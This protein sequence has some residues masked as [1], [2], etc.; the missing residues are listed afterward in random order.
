MNR[1]VKTNAY[2]R[3]RSPAKESWTACQCPIAAN[4]GQ[5]SGG[6]VGTSRGGARIRAAGACSGAGRRAG[7]ATAAWACGSTRKESDGVGVNAASLALQHFRNLCPDASSRPCS[8]TGQWQFLAAWS[9]QQDCTAD[10]M[11][12]IGIATERATSAAATRDVTPRSTALIHPLSST[13]VKRRAGTR[14]PDAQSLALGAR[15]PESLE[16]RT[17]R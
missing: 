6:G 8:Q 15:Y 9:Q 10:A 1:D 17:G 4:C 13:C 16:K 14:R 7:V 3:M 12:N 11:T 2:T 5:A